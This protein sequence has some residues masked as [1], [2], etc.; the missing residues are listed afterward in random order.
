MHQLVLAL[1]REW[2]LHPQRFLGDDIFHKLCCENVLAGGEAA[3]ETARWVRERDAGRDAAKGRV[4][5]LNG[6]GSVSVEWEHRRGET[7]VE[8]PGKL[9]PIAFGHF[10]Q[11]EPWRVGWG[12]RRWLFV[13]WS[14][15]PLIVGR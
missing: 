14:F 1:S 3:L 2:S 15:F 4:R 10:H 7:S 6:D 9:E 11:A 12:F 8:E 13:G 5:A